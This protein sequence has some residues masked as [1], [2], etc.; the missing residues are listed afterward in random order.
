MSFKENLKSELSYQGVLVKELATKT[1]ISRRTLDNYLREKSS[2][3]PVDVAVKIANAL[4]VSV[5][6]LATGKEKSDF[7]SDN[8]FR[9]LDPTY[10]K[11]SPKKKRIVDETLQPLIKTIADADL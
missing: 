7:V 1:G 8:H 5:E 3:P 6:Y 2:L 4:N 10:S 9:I 11:L